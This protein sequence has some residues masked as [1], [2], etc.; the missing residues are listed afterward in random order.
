MFNAMEIQTGKDQ[1]VDKT[2]FNPD[3]AWV[4]NEAI[5]HWLENKNL[6]TMPIKEIVKNEAI[7]SKQRTTGKHKTIT[8]DLTEAVQSIIAKNDA[9]KRGI[10]Q[11]PIQTQKCPRKFNIQ[12]TKRTERKHACVLCNVNFRK[13]YDLKVHNGS[14][15][16][17]KRSHPCQ[18]C[19]ASFKLPGHLK[20]HVEHVHLK[21]RRY[22]CDQ[23]D[24]SYTREDRLINHQQTC[25]DNDEYSG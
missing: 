11:N 25:H 17:N 15:H 22:P 1:P 10:K 19:K 3:N 5:K 20:I 21:M 7:E 16:S 14:V 4:S 6:Q 9:K 23:C 18:H 12:L 13:S 2:N 8:I 24:K